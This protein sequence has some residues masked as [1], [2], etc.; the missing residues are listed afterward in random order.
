MYYE[1]SCANI[2]LEEWKRKM[3]G[4]KPIN[5]RWLVAKI[6]KHLP[7]LYDDL[8]LDLYNPYQ[9]QCRVTRDYYILVWSSIEFFIKKIKEKKTN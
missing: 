5:Y 3:K 2:T 4:S 1:C 8:M 6:K 9:D 7:W